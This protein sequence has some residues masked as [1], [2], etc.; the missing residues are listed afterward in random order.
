[1][2]VSTT[3]WRRL[4]AL[5]FIVHAGAM[6][7][8]ILGLAPAVDA[9]WLLAVSLP[10]VLSIP[11]C[12]AGLRAAAGRE[13]EQ[14]A[15]GAMTDVRLARACPPRARSDAEGRSLPL[16]RGHRRP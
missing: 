9:R 12:K 5:A 1:M 8:L 4:L 3:A 15:M 6:G 16:H 14:L 10:A 7:V 13:L 2:L 11:L